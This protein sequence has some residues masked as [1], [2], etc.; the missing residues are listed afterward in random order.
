MSL[1]EIDALEKRHGAEA[2]RK[3][4]EASEN[5]A[6]WARPGVEEAAMMNAPQNALQRLSLEQPEIGDHVSETGK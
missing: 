4:A 5:G 2:S 1:E 6:E 3:G